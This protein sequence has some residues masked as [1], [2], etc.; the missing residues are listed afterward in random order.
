MPNWCS[1]FLFIKQSENEN[2][3]KL[4]KAFQ[5]MID[6][7][8]IKQDEGNVIPN[9]IMDRWLFNITMDDDQISFETAWGICFEDFKKIYKHFKVDFEVQYEEF[10]S[11]IYGKFY[12]LDGELIKIDLTDEQIDEVDEDDEGVCTF[13]GKVIECK[14][15]ALDFMLEEM[16]AKLEPT[17]SLS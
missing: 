17:C 12:V 5:T 6:L 15:D 14:Y 10:G 4:K 3:K 11:G 2:V 8:T 16:Q 9:I 7:Q 13:R 1:N